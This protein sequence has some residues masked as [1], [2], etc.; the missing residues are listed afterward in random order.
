M[1]AQWANEREQWGAPVGHHEAVAHKIGTIAADLY[2]VESLAWMTSAMADRKETD[3]RLEAAMAKL[4]C[5]ETLWRSVDAALQ[6]R[7]GRG[8]ETADSL[9]ARGELP[10]PMERAMRDARINLIIEGTSEIMRLFIA[11]EALDP[12]MRIAG[13][14]ASSGKMDLMGAA[15]FYT[16]WYPKLWLPL[17]KASAAICVLSRAPPGGSPGT[18]ST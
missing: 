14:S 7:G 2:A 10:V 9:K 17:R 3:I 8:Y 1:A 15:K 12:H 13:I 16:R 4:F 11:R 6:V 5:T 18:C